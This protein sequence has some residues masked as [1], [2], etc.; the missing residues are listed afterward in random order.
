MKAKAKDKKYVKE[1]KRH[2]KVVDKENLRHERKH[3]EEQK[4]AFKRGKNECEKK[5]K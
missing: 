4:G 2:K 3:D 5:K 1:E